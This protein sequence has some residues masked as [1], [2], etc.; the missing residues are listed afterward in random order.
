MRLH[1]VMTACNPVTVLTVY[2]SSRPLTAFGE[3]K[4]VKIFTKMTC[5]LRHRL[6]TFFSE[7]RRLNNKNNTFRFNEFRV[8]P[9]DLKWH[10]TKLI[11]V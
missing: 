4:I 5:D 6:N 10:C 1:T 2:S 9:L 11:F 8:W 7:M 3:K